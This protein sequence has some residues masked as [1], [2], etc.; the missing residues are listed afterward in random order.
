MNDDIRKEPVVT[1]GGN[2]T[3]IRYVIQDP[4]QRAFEAGEGV[5]FS[6]VIACITCF[7]W[8]CYSDVRIT[9]ALLAQFLMR[10]GTLSVLVA[11][12]FEIVG[13]LLLGAVGMGMPLFETVGGI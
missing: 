12:T 9:N 10:G 11:L 6:I 7:A 1:E 13:S 3:V 5:A 2:V 4:G 8:R